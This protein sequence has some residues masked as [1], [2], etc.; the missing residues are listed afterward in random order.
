MSLHLGQH[1]FNLI[2]L[3]GHTASETAVYIPE[4]KVVFTGDNLNLGIPI[5]IKSLPDAWLDSLTAIKQLDVEK[6]VPGHGQVSDKSSIELM[7]E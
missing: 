5:F 7:R 4:E 1:T 3:P 2:N 6:I